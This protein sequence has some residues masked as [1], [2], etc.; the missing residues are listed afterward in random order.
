MP[1]KLVTRKQ[2]LTA[3]PF[4]AHAVLDFQAN[5]HPERDGLFKAGD[6]VLL[7]IE[8]EAATTITQEQAD[9]LNREDLAWYEEVTDALPA[10]K[11]TGKARTF[12][13]AA[14]IAG[15]IQ[16]VVRRN[17]IAWTKLCQAMGWGDTIIIPVLNVPFLKQEN[18]H[19][20]MV[21]ARKRLMATGLPRDYSGALRATPDIA[22]DLIPD[23]FRIARYNA[24]AP[25][26][27]MAAQ[28]SKTVT[29]VCK[30]LNF[31][32]E[33]YDE[34]ETERLITAFSDAGLTH[35]EDG[36]CRQPFSRAGAIGGRRI[37]LR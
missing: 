31:H 7:D 2:A 9:E 34:T 12:N 37:D 20:P 26:I 24:C 1:L 5:I 32:F 19:P 17:G 36:I 35:F 15:N 14:A 6:E 23:L 21:H 3:H 10:P 8:D 27:F 11:G 22:A 13:I 18:P 33:G 16:S 29:A 4:L 30:Y 25:Y 28:G